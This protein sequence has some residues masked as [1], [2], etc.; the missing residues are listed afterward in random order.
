MFLNIQGSESTWITWFRSTASSSPLPNT[1]VITPSL[2]WPSCGL[3]YLSL[4]RNVQ[5]YPQENESGTTRSRPFSFLWQV[6]KM[7]ITASWN[8]SWL[9]AW[10]I[11]TLPDVQ[12]F[13]CPE[14]WSHGFLNKSIPHKGNLLEF[15]ISFFFLFV[16]TITMESNAIRL[17]YLVK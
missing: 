5:W 1:G 7:R 12:W 13:L 16:K 10:A 4:K 11:N 15:K 14:I 3:F 2:A 17:C 9:S 6:K 8:R